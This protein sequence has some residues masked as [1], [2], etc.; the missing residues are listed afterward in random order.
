LGVY[1]YNIFKKIYFGSFIKDKKITES[2]IEATVYETEDSYIDEC[3]NEI[4]SIESFISFSHSGYRPYPTVIELNL[5]NF[6]H[7]VSSKEISYITNI[8]EV[9]EEY[10]DYNNIP[11]EYGGI[12]EFNWNYATYESNE[13][14]AD[15]VNDYFEKLMDDLDET[16]ECNL[17]REKLANIL[18][19]VFKNEEEIDTDK[20]MIRVDP[21]SI[22][23]NDGT[24]MI[25]Y[26]NKELEKF[27]H[28]KVKI[29]NLPNYVYNR[30]LFENVIDIKKLLK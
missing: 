30:Q 12:Y 1:N 19:K 24:V 7:Y 29:E 25:Y 8:I 21:R 22:D 14:L 20:I 26:H 6:M 28:G 13:S 3:N 11:T 16:N 18:H 23:C 2:F 10:C 27:Y 4:K 9:V 5:A 17:Y 15:T